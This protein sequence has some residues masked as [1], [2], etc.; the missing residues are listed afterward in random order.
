M[1][2]MSA[3]DFPPLLV[4]SADEAADSAV[5]TPSVENLRA[6]AW[7]LYTSGTMMETVK[8]GLAK[9]HLGQTA[10][11]AIDAVID[12]Y[13]DLV[14]PANTFLAQYVNA[15]QTGKWPPVDIP[16]PPPIDPKATTLK[17][18]INDIEGAVNTAIVKFQDTKYGAEV[19]NALKALEDG[20]KNIVDTL[21]E[22][23]PNLLK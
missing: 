20:L 23:Y 7:A 8:G 13:V 10:I 18:L 5:A 3:K 2:D 4:L 21:Q 11:T 17:Q 1:N 19:S 22:Y 6:L 12:S 15:V 14:N 16:L 9:A